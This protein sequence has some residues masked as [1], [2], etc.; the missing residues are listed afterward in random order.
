MTK[1]AADAEPDKHVSAATTGKTLKQQNLQNQYITT[2]KTI[3]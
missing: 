1:K 3:I 2:D